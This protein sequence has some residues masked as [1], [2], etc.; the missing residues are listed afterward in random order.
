MS[1]TLPQISHGGN[2]TGT[3]S[4]RSFIDQ[5]G[6]ERVETIH[7]SGCVAGSV[8]SLWGGDSRG[9]NQQRHLLLAKLNTEAE[10]KKYTPHRCLHS[11]EAER[12]R[13]RLVAELA[14]IEAQLT[15]TAE[16]TS[17]GFVAD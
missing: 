1:G 4:A 6:Q 3:N 15:A 9:A 13:V 7:L 5:H 2:F 12:T 10:L 14:A 11:S 8:E 16:E 17:S